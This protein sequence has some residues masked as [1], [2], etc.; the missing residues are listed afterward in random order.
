MTATTTTASVVVRRRRGRLRR[1]PPP[2]PPRKVE[3][4]LSALRLLML[5]V[6]AGW[7]E[8]AGAF[9][10][11]PRGA[12]RFCHRRGTRSGYSG[13]IFY[14]SSSASDNG[15]SS[16]GRSYPAPPS[17]AGARTYLRWKK[18]PKESN[19]EDDGNASPEHNKRQAVW[20]M[21]TSVTT[22]ERTVVADSKDS[23]RKGRM[24]RVHLHAQLHFGNR[25]YFELYNS[26]DFDRNHQAILYELLVD[27]E[28][29]QEQGGDEESPT[30]CHNLL[31]QLRRLDPD[32]FSEQQQTA[33]LLQAS[34]N[35]KA[36][37]Q[38][39]G[40]T[41]QADAIRYRGG[42]GENKW[43]HADLTR[44]EFLRLLEKREQGDTPA[45]SGTD[46][47]QPLWRLAQQRNSFLPSLLATGPANEAATAL[48][49]GP[50]LA[51]TAG[52]RGG[53]SP[54]SSAVAFRQSIFSRTVS[55]L[56]AA[57]WMT[58]P[59]P[60]L[61][62][63]LLDWSALFVD[64]AKNSATLVPLILL[65]MIQLAVRG[66]I[67]AVRQLY[68][69]QVVLSGNS[70]GGAA[71]DSLLVTERNQHAIR[72]L[73]EVLN[74]QQHHQ[75]R[76]GNGGG[77]TTDVALLYGSSHCED[78]H[79]R[80]LSLG[81]VPASKEWRTAFDVPVEVTAAG[82]LMPQEELV[83][84]VLKQQKIRDDV[85]DSDNAFGNMYQGVRSVF[86]SMTADRT[87]RG[88]LVIL[89]AYLTVGG[90]DWIATWESIAQDAVS[91]SSLEVGVD[92]VLYLIRHVLLYVALS[93]LL[94]DWSGNKPQS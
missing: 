94:L 45:K 8:G 20:A 43:I 44:Q 76:N 54:P 55:I 10:V 42:N 28:L 16:D 80:L 7:D 23:G 92:A 31:R 67:Q 65:D 63:L 51:A 74:Q 87:T 13:G 84:M 75:S 82:I 73:E 71:D 11:V 15:G 56:R 29:L 2:L 91:A 64:D 21:Q 32:L 36:L 52:R 19:S 33:S 93:K 47:G 60:E 4:P 62:I 90:L 25:E 46:G 24:E 70:G 1:L 34:A 69:G 37:A 53:R 5:L 9:L 26:P 72:V 14:S 12:P 89:L 22:F 27:E 86:S 68:F 66:R 41:C 83:D 35:D 61:S 77:G 17:V 6:A 38:Q 57:L 18:I 58:V 40:W 3:K 50:P 78:L 85:D 39:Y 48:L 59:A 49:V 81:F 30:G 88:V 79:D